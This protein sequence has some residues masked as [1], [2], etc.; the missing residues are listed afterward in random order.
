MD[1]GAQE[2]CGPFPGER[3]EKEENTGLYKKNTC[4]KPLSRKMREADFCEFL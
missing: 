2:G 4:L 1:H 3:L